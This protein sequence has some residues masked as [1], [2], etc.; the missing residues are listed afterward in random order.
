MNAQLAQ[1][2]QRR[3]TMEEVPVADLK[4]DTRYHDESRF[5]EKRAKEIGDHY[6]SDWTGTIEVSVRDGGM[7]V[8]V[9]GQHRAAGARRAGV[10]YLAAK[11]WHG[12]SLQEEAELF[13]HLNHAVHPTAYVEYRAQL[14][15][16]VPEAVAINESLT[17]IGARVAN[18]SGP[19]TTKS[20]ATLRRLRRASVLDQTLDVVVGAW[21]DG[22]ADMLSA[23]L[24]GGVGAFLLAY[25]FHPH[26]DYRRE[27]LVDV[28]GQ[29]A[30]AVILRDARS[31][32]SLSIQ[33]AQAQ[34]QGALMSTG[35]FER[36]VILSRYN[37][38]LRSKRLNDISTAQSI[39]IG[40]EQSPWNRPA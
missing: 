24:L 14:I 1:V 3:W 36:Q 15:A 12:L 9:D 27:R 7:L 16:L 22:D 39:R 8:V 33:G 35:R 31:L 18:T 19:K 34:Q 38:G 4:V 30:A 20:V 37:S 23:A 40:K 11:V 5:N 29:Q 28:L 25:E 17:R 6:N 13:L 21:P 10:A 32:R 26:P 2:I